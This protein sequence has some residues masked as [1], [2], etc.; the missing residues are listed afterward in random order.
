MGLIGISSL[1]V[2]GGIYV[3]IALAWWILQIVANW[4]IFTKAGEAGWKSIIP[5]YSDYVSYKIAWQT[6]YFW[7]T[8]ILGLVASCVSGLATPDGNNTMILA[9]VSLLRII[10]GIISIMYSVKLAKA[11][12]K[13]TGFAIGLIFLSPIFMLILGLGDSTYYGA[14]K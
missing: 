14:E 9:I 8:F 11:F 13:G 7:I 3:V 12:G 10:A 1:I 4:K 2:L 6:S 5:V